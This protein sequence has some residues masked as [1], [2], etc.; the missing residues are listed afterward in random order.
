[1]GVRQEPK[2]KYI[3]STTHSVDVLLLRQ[4]VVIVN[5]TLALLVIDRDEL[6]QVLCSHRDAG[7]LHSR[8][9]RVR[10]EGAGSGLVM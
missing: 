7:L 4:E 9:E 10:W 3:G 5:N 1:M 2:P 6:L 8:R